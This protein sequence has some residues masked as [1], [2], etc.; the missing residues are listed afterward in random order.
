[1]ILGPPVTG[2]LGEKVAWHYGFGAAGVGMLV[3]L[4]IYLAG[5]R[6]LPPDPPRGARPAP[7]QGRRASR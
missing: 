1:M 3:S 6:Y 4:A 7:R 5:R 2:T